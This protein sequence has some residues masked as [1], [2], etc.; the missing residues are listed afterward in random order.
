MRIDVLPWWPVV[1]V[2]LTHR[3]SSLLV[4]NGEH[5]KK[6]RSVQRKQSHACT[7]SVRAGAGN[8]ARRCFAA[9]LADGV[10][11]R[12]AVHE[13]RG[14]VAAVLHS[15]ETLCVGMVD[16]HKQTCFNGQQLLLLHIQHLG[17][18]T[19]PT[20]RNQTRTPAPGHWPTRTS[21]GRRCRCCRLR[22]TTPRQSSNTFVQPDLP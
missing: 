10:C 11:A 5:A 12:T 19:T 4:A 21:R 2:C 13:V 1:A 6:S 14:A 22:S 9:A 18:N 8:R 16:T 15:A 3:P 20:P 7:L 17:H